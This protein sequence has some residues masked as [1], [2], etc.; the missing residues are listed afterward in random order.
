MRVIRTKHRIVFLFFSSLFADGQSESPPPDK[1]SNPLSLSAVVQKAKAD[2][3]DRVTRLCDS[4]IPPLDE[5]LDDAARRYSV[6]I[7][8]A[9]EHYGL[10]ESDKRI[11]S[12]WRFQI[13][14]FVSPSRVSS[15]APKLAQLPKDFQPTR[16]LPIPPDEVI[17]FRRGGTVLLDGVSVTEEDPQFDTFIDG[18]EY[19]L[20]LAQSEDRLA[21]IPLGSDGSYAILNGGL[22]SSL[23]NAGRGAIERELEERHHSRLDLIVSAL[24][25]AS[26]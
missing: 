10:I 23:R 14:S 17:V 20:F 1:G 8:Q 5:S 9:L 2:G 18:Q 26:R 11:G 3:V 16:Y 25:A 12:W 6:V 15:L 7:V 22:L 19:V 21:S 13:R 4:G 24:R